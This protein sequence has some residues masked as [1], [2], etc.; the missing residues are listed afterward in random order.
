MFWLGVLVVLLVA[1]MVVG[2]YLQTVLIEA[3]ILALYAASLHFVLS[4]GGLPSLG[5]AAYFGLGA[6]AV[7]LA[8]SLLG[9]PTFTSLT[10]AAF[11]ALVAA[12]IFG[13]FCIRLSGIYLAMLT[14]LL[15]RSCGRLHCS[16][17]I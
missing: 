9:M 17:S 6:Y 11:T 2:S 13:W 3:L 14:L 1:P 5:H 12:A 10:I 7:A 15:R 4:I 16:G 8:T